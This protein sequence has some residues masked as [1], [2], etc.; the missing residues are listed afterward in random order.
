MSAPISAPT[1]ASLIPSTTRGRMHAAYVLTL[2]L[3]EALLLIVV[4]QLIPK[5]IAGDDA[6]ALSVWAV[7]GTLALGFGIAHLLGR[8]FHVV[9][10]DRFQRSGSKLNWAR[11]LSNA[12]RSCSM[13][14]IAFRFPVIRR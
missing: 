3:S 8:R 5:L 7:A 4:A 13:S 10:R 9:G 14:S 2:L 12:E 6:E 1:S 11:R